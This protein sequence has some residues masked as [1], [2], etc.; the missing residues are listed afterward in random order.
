[1]NA[2]FV[3]G[4]GARASLYRGALPPAWEVLQPPSFRSTHGR[5]E[6][7]FEWLRGELEPFAREVLAPA[8]I[9]D[10]GWFDSGVVTAILDRHVA[11]RE[12]LSRQIWGLMAFSLW[13][14]RYA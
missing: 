8:R 12:D 5:I 1:M 3:P 7:T 6:A 9:A 2:F 13:H 10:Q 11:G 4:W 14:E